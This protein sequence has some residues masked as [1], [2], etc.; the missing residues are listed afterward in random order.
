MARATQVIAAVSG[1]IQTGDNLDNALNTNN[2][3]QQGVLYLGDSMNKTST[4]P[5]SGQDAEPDYAATCYEFDGSSIIETTTTGL[6]TTTTGSP[7]TKFSQTYYELTQKKIV[8]IDAA[9]GGST[10]YDNGSANSWWSSTGTL[11]ASAETKTTNALA[12][13]GVTKL[14]MIIIR[15]GVNDVRAS[16]TIDESEMLLGVN[17]FFT[18]IDATWPGVPKFFVLPG[19]T[20][21]ITT[22]TGRLATM[23]TYITN[24]VAAT[25]DCYIV[26]NLINYLPMYGNDNL[27]LTQ[28]GNELHATKIAYTML[29]TGYITNNPLVRTYDANSIAVHNRFTGLTDFEKDKMHD[30]VQYNVRKTITA[31]LSYFCFGLLS[32]STKAAQNW[33]GSHVMTI[34]VAG[35]TA[36]EGYVLDGTTGNAIPTGFT[37]SSE[38]GYS[39]N[40]GGIAIWMN[41]IISS[42]VQATVVGCIGANGHFA[43]LS[44]TAGGSEFA[45]NSQT[46]TAFTALA[47][48]Q[49]FAINRAA[50][51]QQSIVRYNS[52]TNGVLAS[53]GEPNAE[54]YLGCLNNAGVLQDPAQFTCYMLAIG[55]GFISVNH[56]SKYRGLIADFLVK[57]G[58]F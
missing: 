3:D 1:R 45:V 32:S 33:F 5:D 29:N 6:S 11:R 23:H 50:G 36:G 10:F 17:S 57:L 28:W 19:R 48:K 38:A 25:D 51:T 2:D 31:S 18:W 14:R 26:D 41:D 49:F 27:H 56:Q 21:S 24:A 40:N 30:F 58:Y 20:E 8:T 47:D 43:H 16:G 12:A 34:P 55:N 9:S 37:P 15:L 4:A 39:Q 42:G 46:D 44:V 7:A 35:W 13:I 22:V 54:I 53:T 52:P